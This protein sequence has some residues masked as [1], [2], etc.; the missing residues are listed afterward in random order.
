[1]DR[2]FLDANVLL[3]A[4]LR[5]RAKLLNLWKVEAATLITSEYAV[6]EARRNLPTPQQRRLVSDACFEA[7][8]SSS[9]VTSRCPEGSICLPRTVQFFW[10]RSI[11]GPLTSSLEILTTS[12]ATTEKS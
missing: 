10:R 7:W 1:M 12:A 2:V 5:P 4:A 6:D 3:S 8:K 11:P 9:S